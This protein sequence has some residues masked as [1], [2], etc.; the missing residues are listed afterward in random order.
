MLVE[1]LHVCARLD[2]EI[3]GKEM[4][5]IIDFF[6]RAG[7]PDLERI[8]SDMH[9]LVRQAKSA[10]EVLLDRTGVSALA[11]LNTSTYR[12]MLC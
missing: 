5:R 8:N 3:R 4:D 9:G 1:G 2:H 12:S 7:V 6:E 10:A 11:I